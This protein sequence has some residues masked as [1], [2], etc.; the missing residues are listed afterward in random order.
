MS[1]SLNNIELAEHRYFVTIKTNML[2]RINE[3]INQLNSRIPII[4]DWVNAFLNRAGR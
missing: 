4:N 3:I 1:N 2:T